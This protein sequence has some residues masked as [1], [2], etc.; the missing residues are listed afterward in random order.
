[1]MKKTHTKANDG[2]GRPKG[3]HSKIDNLTKTTRSNVTQHKMYTS[4][5]AFGGQRI[6]TR[7]NTHTHFGGLSFVATY[8]RWDLAPLDSFLFSL[9]FWFLLFDDDS[10]SFASAKLSN[11]THSPILEDKHSTRAMPRNITELVQKVKLRER[12]KGSQRKWWWGKCRV[13]G[14][15]VAWRWWCV[16]AEACRCRRRRAHQEKTQTKDEMPKRTEEKEKISAKIGP[17]GSTA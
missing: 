6:C 15:V 4:S 11:D 10:F 9:F 8:K 14:G 1:M 17:S 12:K 5:I 3:E 16:A 7:V 2:V 13:L